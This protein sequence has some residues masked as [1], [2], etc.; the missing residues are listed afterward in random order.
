[1]STRV[2]RGQHW[3]EV[4]IRERGKIR[5][6]Q[7]FDWTGLDWSERMELVIVRDT[8]TALV[9]GFLMDHGVGKIDQGGIIG[10]ILPYRSV[11]VANLVLVFIVVLNFFP[12][13]HSFSVGLVSDCFTFLDP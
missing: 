13:V 3:S 4:K 10:Y 9:L 12:F 5:Q 1:M 2:T 11:I 8:D 6:E 7:G